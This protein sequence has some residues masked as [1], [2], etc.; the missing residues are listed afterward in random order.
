[1]QDDSSIFDPDL[2]DLSKNEWL[3][4]LAGVSE[5]HGFF[6]SLGRKHFASHVRQGDTLLV[7]FQTIQSVP[8]SGHAEPMGWR[9]VRTNGWSSLCIMCD[10]DTWFRDPMVYGLFDS[11]IDEG[12]FDGF[13]TV[14]FYGTGPCGYAAAAFS[15]SAPGARVVAIQPQA[16]LDPRITEW[17]DRF[18]DMRR[19]DFTSRY[20]YAP[21]MLDA[22][23][24]AFVFYDPVERLDAM[25]AALFTRDNVTQFR[26]RNMGG[27]LENFLYKSQSLQPILTHAAE[28]TLDD[29]TFARL[30]RSR[31]DYGP[32][33]RRLLGVLY[34]TK[35]PGLEW[36]LASNVTSRMKAPRFKNRLKALRKHQA[37]Q[38]TLAENSENEATGG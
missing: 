19:T 36:M 27:A 3:T 15:V 11:L 9:V 18:L 21:D 1:M 20:G 25:H 24:D 33:L 2:T 29:S 5:E 38:Q 17:D 13:E 35:R 12:F 31:R 10:G 37:K 6:K 22:C 14:V 8:M 23:K 4:T 30:Y 26:L 34:L 28:G 32:Y 7:S 16:T